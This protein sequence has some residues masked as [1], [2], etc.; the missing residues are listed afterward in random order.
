MENFLIDSSIE[1]GKIFIEIYKEYAENQ[2][3][4]LKYIIEKINAVNID[5]LECKEINIQEP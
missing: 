5:V 4:L 1:K 2:N 3:N